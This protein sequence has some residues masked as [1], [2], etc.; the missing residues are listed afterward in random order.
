MAKLMPVP[1]RGQFDA[2]AP[3][4]VQARNDATKKWGTQQKRFFFYLGLLVVWFFGQPFADPAAAHFVVQ[5][6]GLVLLALATGSL[7]VLGIC[8][9][10]IDR[11]ER[12]DNTRQRLLDKY[13]VDLEKN[14]G[15]PVALGKALDAKVQ[16]ELEADVAAVQ[17][18]LVGI[19]SLLR[20]S[21][22]NAYLEMFGAIRGKFESA[23]PP[24]GGSPPPVTP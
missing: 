9:E 2:I 8:S 4:V 18:E 10:C 21:E 5:S 3:R 16:A 6:L 20:M 14:E 11:L 22:V 19:A 12:I 13:G 24:A 7:R 23:N 15:N 17:N 1:V